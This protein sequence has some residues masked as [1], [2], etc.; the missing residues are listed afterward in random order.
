[1]ALGGYILG[2]IRGGLEI[3]SIVAMSMFSIVFIGS[4]IGIT[5]PFILTKLKNYPAISG[6]QVL[7]SICDIS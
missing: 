5:L 3:A 4:I 2:I 7:T 1:M 6:S